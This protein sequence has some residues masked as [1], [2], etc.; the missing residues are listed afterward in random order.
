MQHNWFES[1]SDYYIDM[2]LCNLTL[3]DYIHNRTS[4]IEQ[5]P[6]FSNHA[7]IFVSDDCSAHL[8]LLNI[9]TIIHHIAQGLEFIHQEHYTHR[10]IK[11]L[12]GNYNPNEILI[13]VLYSHQTR[14]WKITDFGLSSETRTNVAHTTK[15]S[16]GTGGYRA[17]ELLAEDAKYT[18][19]VDIWA[20]GCILYELCTK[21]KAFTDDWAVFDFY[22]SSESTLQLSIPSL[23]ATLVMHL[24]ECIR[25]TMESDPQSRPSIS[26]FR[27]LIESYCILLDLQTLESLSS[28]PDYSQWKEM[29]P[30]SLTQGTRELFVSLAIWYDSRGEREALVQLLKAKF[31]EDKNVKE[32]L[33]ERYEKMEHWDSAIATWTDLVDHNPFEE[34]LLDNLVTARER[35]GDEHREERVWKELAEKHPEITHFVKAHTRVKLENDKALFNA[36]K[37]GD[38]D[39]VRR[40]LD[41][42]GDVNAQGGLYGNALQAASSRGHEAI[43]KLLLDKG[44]D[45]NAQG[46]YYGNALQA[47]SYRGDKA[48]VRLLLDRGADVNAQG[49]SYGNALQAA[50]L[51][52]HEAI[53]KLLLDK[54]A[55][56]NAQDGYY[57]NALQVASIGGREAIVRLLLDRGADINAHGGT[58]GNALQAASSYGF[59]AS[60]QL[61]L[62]KGADVNAQGGHYG[63]ALQAA[64]YRGHEMIVRLLLDRGADINAQG[65]ICGN[66]LQA[67]LS[68]GHVAIVRLLR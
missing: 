36:A 42:D 11:P 28:M 54:G 49:G 17:P 21:T 18:Y 14:A 53:V 30:K 27:P 7:P 29:V 48:I 65:G 24:S 4:F 39:Q 47:V 2:E 40:L 58:L 26:V 45:V 62:D 51:R 25:E 8:N 64:S 55:D 34:R 38:L 10:D 16:R 43:V 35:Q 1:S 19:Q 9:C 60:V 63:N 22:K 67:A 59:K 33:A 61:L 57:G 20:L 12:N 56:A 3:Q 66:A 44:A 32:C 15:Y 46:G 37:N 50:S 52:G 68:R 5:H 6:D 23:P 41:M 31:P 13:S